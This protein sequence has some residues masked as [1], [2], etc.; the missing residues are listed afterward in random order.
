MHTHTDTFTLSQ[1]RFTFVTGQGHRHTCLTFGLDL[2]PFPQLQVST[3]QLPGHQGVELQCGAQTRP[4][5]P[6]TPPAGN[7]SLTVMSVLKLGSKPPP[8]PSFTSKVTHSHVS[9]TTSVSQQL[10]RQGHSQSRQFHL[11]PTTVSQVWSLTVTPVSPP[12]LHHSVTC[13]VT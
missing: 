7:T 4:H 8:H 1:T 10:D 3:L 6:Q 2:F 9:F 12:L 5:L 13:T 11:C